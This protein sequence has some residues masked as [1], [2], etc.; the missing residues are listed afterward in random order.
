MHRSPTIGRVE[1]HHAQFPE[2]ALRRERSGA[3]PSDLMPAAKKATDRV[4]EMELHHVPRLRHRTVAE[5]GRP[6]PNSTVQ[7]AR[8]LRPRRLVSRPQS[9]TNLVPNGSH[10]FLRRARTVIASA[11]SRRVHGPEGVSSPGELHPE[12]LAEPDVNLSA[13]PA[14][15]KQTCRSYRSPSGQREPFVTGQAVAGTGLPGSYGL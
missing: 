7:S 11:S 9:S 12:A 5:V 2:H 15:I 8:D 3:K 1:R 4:I 13:H 10:G 6:S 14:P